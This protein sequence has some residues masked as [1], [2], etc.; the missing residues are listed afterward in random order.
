MYD[1]PEGVPCIVL[2][3][4]KL[5]VAGAHD[6]GAD[7]V[8]VDAARRIDADHLRQERGVF[9]NQA[10]RHA[11]RA[12]DFLAVIDVVKKGIDGAHPLF[13]AT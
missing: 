12:Q 4:E 1:T 6:I 2:Q 13:D 9:G 5:V 11:A 8:G 10:D 7:D 3:H